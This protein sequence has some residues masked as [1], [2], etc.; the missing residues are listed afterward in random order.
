MVDIAIFGTG[1]NSERAW[2]AAVARTDINVTCFADNDERKHGTTLHDRPVVSAKQ[3]ATM[4]W[5]F[6]VVASMY[7]SQIREQLT[8]LGVADQAI[9]TPEPAE[10]GEVLAG[11][12]ARQRS[13]ALLKLDDGTRVP[14]ADLPSVLI[15][16]YETLN[17]T[18]GTGVLLQRYFAD[19]PEDRLFSVCHTATGLPWLKRSCVLPSSAAPQERAAALARELTAASFV[20][21]LVYVT[22]FNELDLELLDTV[23][24][25]VPAG[26][27]IIQHFMDY[28]PHDPAKFDARF[29]AIGG[30]IT[31]VWALT[32]GLAQDL[33][34]RYARPV[35][36]VS[37]LHQTPSATW[38]TSYADAP[39]DVR[40]LILG[41]L[42]QPW[43]LPVINRVWGRCRDAVPGLAPLDWYVH[44]AR[45]QSIVDAGYEIGDHIVWRGFYGGQAL[46]QRLQRAELAVMPFNTT[47]H[48]V[49]GYTRFSLPSRLTE[50][51]GAGLPIF[52]L[53][54]ADTEPARFLSAKS[55]GVCWNGADEDGAV[56]VLLVLINDSELRRRLG[57][58]ARAVA[59][60]DFAFEAFHSR[61]LGLF[62]RLVEEAPRAA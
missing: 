4:R 57:A 22:A 53:A 28:M 12:A 11:V 30:D 27:P 13:G 54:S 39:R 47:D 44:P 43:T 38:K 3:L 34:R 5:D 21:Q 61:L 59:E 46:Q 41:N 20:P 25:V 35:E 18:H 19:F 37:A 48:A 56:D 23:R 40:G 8:A 49:D 2:Q 29:S 51:C 32:D 45:V 55:C 31:A 60:T 15:L 14:A 58:R 36:H 62:M 50:L 33:R 6:V 16:T 52:S 42:W 7:S 17:S 24:A 1:S 26:V 9:V 10:F